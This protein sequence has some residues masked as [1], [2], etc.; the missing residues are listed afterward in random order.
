MT[1]E[2]RQILNPLA[3]EL[4]I[5]NEGLW[6]DL[7]YETQQGPEFVEF[8]YFPSAIEFQAPAQAAI[9]ALD[10]AAKATLV[11]AWRSRPRYPYEFTDE[12]RILKQYAVILV[13][14]IVKR[15]KQAGARTTE[16]W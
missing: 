7:K 16:F 15:A 9:D 14:L 13:D 2:E 10:P 4:R 11:A 6:S 1:A 3:R 8:P 5:D 12:A